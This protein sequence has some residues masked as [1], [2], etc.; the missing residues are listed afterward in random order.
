MKDLVERIYN[1]ILVC[2]EATVKIDNQASKTIRQIA[3]R[4][5]RLTDSEQETLKDILYEAA[6]SAEYAGIKIGIK[7][8]LGLLLSVYG[9]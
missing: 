6:S 8:T 1:D 9:D 5:P 7:F 2:E 4:Y 3:G